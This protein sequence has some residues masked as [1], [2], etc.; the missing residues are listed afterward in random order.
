M[1]RAMLAHPPKGYKFIGVKTSGKHEFIKRLSK[2]WAIKKAYHLFL[3]IF[4]SKKILEMAYREKEMPEADIMYCFGTSYLGD[5][6]FIVDLGDSPYSLSGNSYEIFRRNRDKIEKYLEKKNCMHII[7]PHETCMDFMKENFSKKVA[8]KLALVRPAIDLP[9]YAL[10]KDKFRRSKKITI[11]FMGS[12]NNPKDF[13]MKGGLEA[14][15]AFNKISREVNAELII[16]CKVPERVK[17]IASKNPKIK[18]IEDIL[19]FEKIQE[20]YK[21]A[22]ILLMPNHQYTLTVTLEGMHYGLPIISLNTWAVADHM[23]N[24]FNAFLIKPSEK[25]RGYKNKEY[26]LNIRSE[27]FIAEVWRRYPEP[28]NQIANKLKILIENPGLRNKMGLN[29]QKFAKNRF[30]I[31]ERNKRF[32]ALLER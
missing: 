25:I 22:D 17:E 13:Y 26:P 4:K 11:I 3:K 32:G 12:I 9:K 27:E 19:P 1:Y 16:R 20:I 28:I 31:E 29:S 23:K 2:V 6:P 30:S 8:K 5:K 15:E 7:C 10:P 18:I 21:R 24:N 14:V